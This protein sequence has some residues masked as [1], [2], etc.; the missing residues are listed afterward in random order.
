MISARFRPS[1]TPA[2]VEVV[3][4]EPPSQGPLSGL[5]AALR[6]SQTTHLL[7]LAIDLPE[8]TA[9]HLMELWQLAWPEVGVIPQCDQLYEPLAAIYPATAVSTAEHALAAGQLSMQ[10]LIE[11]LLELNNVCVYP[12][13]EAD[14]HFY[15]NVNS[16]EDLI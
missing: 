9:E 1:W 3:L 6:H 11:N 12:I 2:D 4:D 13:R 15:R 14:R 7:A 8:M 10:S 16:R 5:C